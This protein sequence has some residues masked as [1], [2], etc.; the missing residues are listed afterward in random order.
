MYCMAT[1]NAMK[2]ERLW[3]KRMLRHLAQSS[4]NSY[5]LS[6]FSIF[7]AVFLCIKALLFEVSS[8][9]SRFH[10]KSVRGLAQPTRMAIEGEI[11]PASLKASFLGDGKAKE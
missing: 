9:C 5:E 10:T 8:K 3:L 11:P 2:Q 1:V 4:T 7:D 6:G